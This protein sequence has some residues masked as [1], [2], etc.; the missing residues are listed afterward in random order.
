VFQWSPSVLH[1]F[2]AGSLPFDIGPRPTG[3]I[4][5]GYAV[6]FGSK[7]NERPGVL[8]V[9]KAFASA[10]LYDLADNYGPLTGAANHSGTPFGLRAYM[11]QCP[12][13]A[14]GIAFS[15][16]F[17]ESRKGVN[18]SPIV[19]VI[20]AHEPEQ[21]FISIEDIPLVLSE[22]RRLLPQLREELHR[23]WPV[24]SVHIEE[25]TPRRK[26]PF[27]AMQ[28]VPAACIGLV[29]VFSSAVLK[30]A[31]TRIGEGIGDG[32]KPFVTRWLK[33]QFT[34]SRTGLMPPKK[35]NKR[36]ISRLP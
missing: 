19:R 11:M 24:E 27:D 34:K 1:T 20:T 26:N 4:L 23:K 31:G 12:R 8:H 10:A 36:R 2:Y 25:R 7:I 15:V 22:L 18:M 32:I 3:S 5:I 6:A 30:A 17:S 13:S 21:L 28:V 9:D 16:V 29:I 14:A 35:R 33:M